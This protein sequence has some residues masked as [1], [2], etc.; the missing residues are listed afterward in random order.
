MKGT[1]N[2][3]RGSGTDDTGLW[4]CV[5]LWQQFLEQRSN[6][7]GNKMQREV[8]P[9]VMDASRDPRSHTAY[10]RIPVSGAEDRDGFPQ[11]EQGRRQ[12]EWS[13]EHAACVRGSPHPHTAHA[14]CT[15]IRVCL[16][17]W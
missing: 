17:R 1:V 8:Q 13:T 4:G 11:G 15:P 7:V 5:V 3:G 14:L 6:V 10:S 16:H 12:G 9:I 2:F